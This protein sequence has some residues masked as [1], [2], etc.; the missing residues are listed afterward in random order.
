VSEA[1]SPDGAAEPPASLLERLRAEPDR[2]AE[3]VALAAAERFAGPARRF[4]DCRRAEGHGPENIARHAVRGHVRIARAEGAVVGA[5][6]A[7][8][9]I[10]DLCALAWLQSRMVFFVAAAHGF[11][12]AHP[13]RPAELLALQDL[14]ETP[15]D[16]R[17]AL[18]RTGR[19]L[20][21]A[22]VSSRLDRAGERTLRSRLL[23]FVSRRVALRVGARVVPLLAS[24]VSAV[25]NGRVTADLGERALRYYGG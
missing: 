2:A 17:A 4:V 1:L 3:I 7:V 20:A 23:R 19:P 22:Y 14:Y 12:P 21:V 10:P 16:A 5:G 25:Q 15:A 9:V 13:M 11:D 18:D 8:T 6:G 24:G